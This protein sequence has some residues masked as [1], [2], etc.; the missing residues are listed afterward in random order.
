MLFISR[1][2]SQFLV[3]KGAKKQGIWD[4]W[5]FFCCQFHI[6][7]HH[8]GD[9]IFDGE[10]WRLHQSTARPYHKAPV[11]LMGMFECR[12]QNYNSLR[13][14]EEYQSLTSYFLEG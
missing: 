5:L 8:L 10:L 3:K 14:F 12:S 9:L 2:F 13:A 7:C 6:S 4:T 1:L 11:W